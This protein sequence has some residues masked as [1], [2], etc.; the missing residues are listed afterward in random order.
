MHLNL[1]LK[2][3]VTAIAVAAT[4]AFAGGAYAAT[5]ASQTSPRE[6]FLSDAAKRLNVTPARLSGALQSAF[7]DQLQ[8]A[9]GA[10]KLTQAQADEIKQRVK[11]GPGAP[12][13]FPHPQLGFRG[14]QRGFATPGPGFG[15]GGPA[16]PGGLGPGSRIGAA[17]S[18][19]GLTEQQLFKQL[20][21][22]KSLAELAQAR[23]KSLGGLQAAM[24]AAIHAR[25]DKAVSAK[26]LTAAQEQQLLARLPARLDAEI[27]E[28]GVHGLRG[29]SPR[30]FGPRA[31]GAGGPP[32]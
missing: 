11:S 12:G 2:R 16:G 7:L 24:L 15:P 1:K 28:N 30:G 4:A 14:L 5:Q 25:L 8:A 26:L 18:Y 10:G 19:L 22:G 29:M 27:N 17:A 20:A 23:G 6:A 21:A 32:W 3:N 13:F 9:V 31:F